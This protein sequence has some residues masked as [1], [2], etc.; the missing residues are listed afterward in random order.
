MIAKTLDK[1][2]TTFAD[3]WA[4]CPFRNEMGIGRD[5]IVNEGNR[6]ALG[7][8]R[9]NRSVSCYGSPGD[10]SMPSNF[11]SVL[12]RAGRPPHDLLIGTLCLPS[13]DVLSSLDASSYLY[14][15]CK[16][17]MFHVLVCR[18]ITFS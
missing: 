6:Y 16:C 2:Q 13:N 8:S 18:S 5:L 17:K 4:S 1:W 14:K 15:S 11:V 7:V 12:H 10:F 3:K 9:Q